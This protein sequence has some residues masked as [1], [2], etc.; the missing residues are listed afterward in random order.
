MLPEENIFLMTGLIFK[1]YK[2]LNFLEYLF[3]FTIL[4]F[5]IYSGRCSEQGIL[6]T[7]S[8]IIK[9]V[10]QLTYIK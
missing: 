6:G 9:G 8:K 5:E 7:F 1:I 2:I 4:A 10:K 3:Q